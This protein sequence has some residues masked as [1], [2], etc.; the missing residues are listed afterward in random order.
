MAGSIESHGWLQGFFDSAW[1]P[2][3]YMGDPTRVY[4]PPLTT[5]TLG[6]LAA[7]VGDVFVAYRVFVTAAILLLGLSVFLVSYRWGGNV[8][9]AAAGAVLV[10]TTPYTLRTLFAEGNLPRMLALLPF[11]WLIWFTERVLIERRASTFLAPLSVL[12]AITVLAHVM[13]AAIFAVILGIYVAIRAVTMHYIPLRRVV[14]A[15]AT[16]M[17][18]LGLA[19]FYVLPAYGRMELAGIPYMPESKIDLFSINLDAFG[20]YH[21]SIE[22]IQVGTMLLLLAL[23]IGIAVRKHH[24]RALLVT[25]LI[26]IILAFGDSGVLFG[27]LPVR[28]ALLPERFL[29][30]SVLLFALTIAATPRADFRR[31]WLLMGCVAVIV[32]DFVPAARMIHM[33]AVPGDE[34]VLAQTMA[35]RPLTGRAA[36]LILPNPN[37]AQI[38]LMSVV[39]ERENVS[40]WALE[41]TPHHHSI[42]RLI[43]AGD[44]APDY[45][46]ATLS[47]WHAD[48]FITQKDRLQGL[49][50]MPF[51]PVAESGEYQLW[52]RDEPSAFAQIVA[53][54]QMLI[55]GD[56]A[57]SWMYAFPFASEGHAPAI[58]DYSPEYLSR[59]AAIGINRVTDPGRIE[60]ALGE[61]VRAGGTLVMDLSGTQVYY[62]GGFS[63]FGVQTMPLRL[64]SA[65]PIVS[66]TDDFGLPPRFDIPP[67]MPAWVGNTYL[68]L[69]VPLVSIT[70]D[71]VDYPLI[72]YRDFG[73]GRIWFVGFNLLYWLD[74]SDRFDLVAPVV[75]T[76]LSHADVNS[77]VIPDPLPV[78]TLNR[79]ATSVQLDYTLDDDQFVVLS[80]TYFP[81]WRATLDGQAIPIHNHQH[82]VA[83]DLPAG[84]HLV[85]LE[86]SPYGTASAL[87]ALVSLVSAG[88]LIGVVIYFYRREPLSVLD[89]VQSFFE[90]YE[91][92][93]PA[94]PDAEFV[95]CPE[96]GNP[97]AVVQPPTS[98]TYPFVSIRCDKC[99]FHG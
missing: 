20:T 15:L 92:R 3:W 16:V 56:N 48:Y 19:A 22:A 82:L 64:S 12:W 47:L 90:R 97:T 17:V 67:E 77:D 99:G 28:N 54:N 31:R 75:Q 46:T 89:R 25:G 63:L 13:Q 88:M 7:A 38:Y 36:P 61:W 1:L 85:E 65:V 80:Q 45:L 32:V 35:E 58:G 34:Y 41:N 23:V 78:R 73:A 27:V 10:M 95:Q 21:Q 8:W 83:L 44:R 39:G 81:R 30:A 93:R 18:G 14:L 74:I 69:D 9:A 96:C 2:D 4:Y 71:G 86:F 6:L 29:N 66:H 91:F 70:H 51:S 68:G 76:I 40:G 11:P 84:Q 72:G 62:E 87:G 43:S 26:G 42:R 50:Q 57:T 37:S 24:Q 79:T 60:S 55:V 59:F 98:E 94:E 53:H 52:E 5:W 33:R 49:A